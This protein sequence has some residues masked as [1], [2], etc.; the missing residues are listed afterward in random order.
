LPFS[1]FRRY[2]VQATYAMIFSLVGVPT[3]LAAGVFLIQRYDSK[4]GQIVYGSK[5]MFVPA[6][7]VCL[8]LSLLPAFVGFLFGLSSAGQ[9]RNDKQSR[10]WIGF[11]VGGLVCTLDVIMVLAFVLLRFELMT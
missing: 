5:G 3:C 1:A 8:A 11:F 10:S 7:A 4:M 6:L 9:R 2:D